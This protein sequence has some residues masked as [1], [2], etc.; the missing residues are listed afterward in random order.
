L[1]AKNPHLV[2]HKF[3]TFN[4]PLGR[5]FIMKFFPRGKL[6]AKL[7]GGYWELFRTKTPPPQGKELYHRTLP[8]G[9]C[10]NW[11]NHPTPKKK[12]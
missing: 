4:L 3:G 6:L 10:R 1:E 8:A 2:P 11:G 5:N 12:S 9:K 7:V